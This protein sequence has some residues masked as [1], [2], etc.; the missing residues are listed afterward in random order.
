MELRGRPHEI[1][2]LDRL[3]EA[4]RAGESQVLVL[5]GEAGV[6]KTALLDYVGGHAPGC[7]RSWWRAWPRTMRGSCWSRC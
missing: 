3:V 2:F 7:Q 4:V 6:G 5:A 1:G